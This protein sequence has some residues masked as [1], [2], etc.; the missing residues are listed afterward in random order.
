M[1]LHFI[2][3]PDLV[4]R[5]RVLL[6]KEIQELKDTAAVVFISPVQAAQ[7]AIVAGD[8][9]VMT[10]FVPELLPIPVIEGRN[11]RPLYS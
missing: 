7:E 4:E 2:V 8:I 3:S 5:G 9:V 1:L 6:C 11:D 10:N